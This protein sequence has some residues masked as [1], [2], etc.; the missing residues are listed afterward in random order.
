MIGI[1][2]PGI[3]LDACKDVRVPALFLVYPPYLENGENDLSKIYIYLLG[4]H[5]GL[6]LHLGRHRGLVGRHGDLFHHPL[7]KLYQSPFR[8]LFYSESQFSTFK[9]G[10]CLKCFILLVT[11]QRF[12]TLA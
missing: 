1:V 2:L 3:E 4:R 6:P 9:S 11:R 12:L 8:D 7:G 10:I 5:G